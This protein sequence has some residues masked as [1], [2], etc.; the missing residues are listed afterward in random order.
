MLYCL[1]KSVFQSHQLA[2]RFKSQFQERITMEIAFAKAQVMMLQETLDWEEA[3][4]RAWDKK[5]N[6]F[7]SGLGKLFA[8]PKPDEVKITHY[9]KRWQPFW[10]VRCASRYI[11]DRTRHYQV[12]I[13][14][15]EVRTV[16]IDEREYV[17]S[18][19]PRGF[20]LVGLEKCREEERSEQ[21]VDAI[22]NET[23]EWDHYLEFESIPLPDLASWKP[24]DS[25]V[26]PA[27]VSA[28]SIVKRVLAV[29]IK[30]VDA[31]TIHQDLLTIE[32]IDL[33]YRPVYAFEFHWLPKD[34]TAIAEIDGLTG[35]LSLEGASIQQAPGIPL[36]DEQLFDVGIDT[37]DRIVPGGGHEIKLAKPAAEN[38]L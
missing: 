11:Y 35:K 2:V 24:A 5:A 4:E 16:V 6:V 7:A 30:P 34:R 12:P 3:K 32:R 18:G 31:D 19:E 14:Q 29:L 23:R 22:N 37:I 1:T 38:N 13:P 36:P 20:T 15:V 17:P 28:S 9:E 27:Q 8:R 25:I 10:Y 21:I 26:V 33:Y